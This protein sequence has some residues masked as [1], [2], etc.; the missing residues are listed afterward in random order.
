VWRALAND[1]RRQLLDLLRDG[2][3]TTGSLAAELPS[4][5]RYAVMQHLEVLVGAGLVVAR[6]EGRQRFNHLNAVPLQQAYE[7]WVQPLARGPAARATALKRFVEQGEPVMTATTQQKPVRAVH[8]ENEIRI[9]AARSRVFEA[10]TTKQ[11]EWYP[12][13]YGQERLKKIVFEE[14]VGGQVYE[15]WGDGAGFMYGTVTYYDPPRGVATRGFVK[16]GVTLETWLIFEED[17]DATVLKQ[18]MVAFGEISD[19]DAEGIQSH[20][21]LRAVEKQL[22]EWCE[23]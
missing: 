11:Q 22:K 14:R 1:S 20:G 5:S 7:R 3:A 6:R 2:A 10:L 23:R 17:G 4:L 18:T 16:G 13:N 9:N 19:E 21:N 15:D 12:Y 8:I